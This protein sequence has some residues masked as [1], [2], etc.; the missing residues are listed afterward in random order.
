MPNNRGEK[1]DPDVTI[2]RPTGL[3]NNF[4]IPIYHKIT[5]QRRYIQFSKKRLS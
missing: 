3:F 2:C 4:A 5:Y 1:G